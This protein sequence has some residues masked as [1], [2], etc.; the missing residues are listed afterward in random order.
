MPVLNITLLEIP[1]FAEE[2][3]VAFAGSAPII[4]WSG[5][6][7]LLPWEAGR[8]VG[9]TADRL[10]MI[11]RLMDGGWLKDSMGFLGGS[12]RLR[13]AEACTTTRAV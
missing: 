2:V 5:A 9:M 11:G 3:Q 12:S 13:V 1:N 8:R 4:L 7:L 10:G 6:L